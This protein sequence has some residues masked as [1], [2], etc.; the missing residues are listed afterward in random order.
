M[1]AE[2]TL[3]DHLIAPRCGSDRTDV[4]LGI[5]DDCALLAPPAGQQL[6]V[7]LDVLVA[8]VHF[9]PHTDPV[10][11][12]HKALAVNLSDLAASGAEAAW[13]TLGLTLPSADAGWLAAFMD[14][15][16][17]L[18]AQHGARLVGGDT[19]RGPLTIAVQVHGF[20]PPGAALTRRG[21]RPGDWVCI[22]G[23]PGEAAAGLAHRLGRTELPEPFASQCLARLDRP[24]PRL[25]AGLVLRGLASA[26]IDVSDGLAQDLGHVLA[27]SGCGATLALADLPATAV[28]AALGDEAAWPYALAGGDDYE[29]LFTL[30]AAHLA[31]AEAGLATA[32]CPF[33]VIGRTDAEP[34]LRLV[35]PDGSPFLLARSGY[36]H[37]G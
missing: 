27:A 14:G 5:G 20:V 28:S 32:G 12:G 2:F 4:V 35:R 9:L 1:P 34:G 21:A 3:I 15:F 36:E 8:G 17:A 16:G 22:T 7:S 10:D 26:C 6:A 31:A 18:A 29:L 13:I 11:L 25:A 19:T 23:T 37:F 24:T 30:P 33:T